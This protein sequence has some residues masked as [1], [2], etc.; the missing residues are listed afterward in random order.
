MKRYSNQRRNEII[1]L[2]VFINSRVPNRFHVPISALYFRQ[3]KKLALQP[4]VRLVMSNTLTKHDN[5]NLCNCFLRKNAENILISTINLNWNRT[6]F[7]E[8]RN[9]IAFTVIHNYFRSIKTKF[10]FKKHYLGVLKGEMQA[11]FHCYLSA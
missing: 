6:L 8:G 2:Q 7:Y 4:F 11:S 9:W 5:F 1:N 3:S 10:W